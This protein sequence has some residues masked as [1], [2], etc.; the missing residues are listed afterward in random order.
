MTD[1]INK[2]T[3]SKSL[4]L[5]SC[6]ALVVGNMIGSGVFLLPATL[7]AY[8]GI[9]LLGWLFTSA[10]ALV[11]AMLFA[12]LA[13]SAP[14][15]GGPYAWSRS[16]L[17]DF[18]GFLVAW[19]FWISL[20]TGNA[21]IAVAM[22]SYLSVFWEPLGGQPII[23]ASAA[24]G[25]IALLTAINT[26]GVRQAGIVQLITTVLKL[27]PLVAV[28]LCGAFWFDWSHFTP[29]NLS[30]QPTFSAIT[31]TATLTLWAFLGLESATV[32]AGDVID[33]EKT[34]PRAT[35]LGTLVATAI[36]IGAT[37]VLFG[38]ITPQELATSQAPFADAASRMW[39][40]WGGMLVA[41]GAAISCFGALN[42]WI[43]NTGQIPAA[44]ANDGVFPKW[45]ARKSRTGTPAASLML[46]AA[47]VCLLIL[48]NYTRGLVG[49]F[50]F[51][52]L[53][54]TV[55]VLVP[56]VFSAIA[57]MVLVLRDGK[58]P[59]GSTVARTIVI[60]GLAFAYSIWAIAGSGYEAVYWGFLLL[61]C[62][63]PFYVLTKRKPVE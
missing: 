28:T 36:Y 38:M 23:G 10:G 5:W 46:S 55:A 63:M 26:L 60:S 2:P 31:A 25:A 12:G 33:P 21:A 27:L 51:A 8:G 6:T 41:A 34:I 29:F 1:I 13:R 57:Q 52:I 19:G 16:G 4:G 11:L 22:V 15:T 62:G 48:A 42:G 39:G 61:L 59:A 50:Q 3:E 7:A 44:A 49:L 17:G 53:L 32:P 47:L 58:I 56:Y 20:L 30:D 24:I 37:V 40:P 18:A 54:S 9:S 43:L 45:F 35:M 14:A